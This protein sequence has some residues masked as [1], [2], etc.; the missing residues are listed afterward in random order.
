[1]ADVYSIH[2]FEDPFETTPPPAFFWGGKKKY[3]EFS[4]TVFVKT[5]FLKAGA[6]KATLR[7]LVDKGDPPS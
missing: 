4:Y 7:M 5:I 2:V 6:K 3:R 1:M